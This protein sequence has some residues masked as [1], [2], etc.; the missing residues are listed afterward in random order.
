MDDRAVKLAKA[1]AVF[2]EKSISYKAAK[3]LSKKNYRSKVKLAESKAALE[4][5]RADLESIRLDIARTAIRAPFSGVLDDV[6]AE[7]GDFIGVGDV[8]AKVI[9]LDPIIIVG[10]I[11][12]RDAAGLA[13][14]APARA[15]LADGKE[16]EGRVRYVSRAGAAVTRTFRTEISVPNPDSRIAE[17]LTAELSL[18]AGKERAHRVSPAVLT[19]SDE[20]AVGVKSVDDNNQVRFHIVSMVADTPDGIWISGLPETVRVITVGQ[21]FVKTGRKVKPVEAKGEQGT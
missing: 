8:V 12:E 10:E 14:G 6:P 2:D 20:G 7:V 21:E 9:D 4:E 3:Q 19:L 13:I 18:E 16:L 11:A 17:G 5:A 15:R 1:E